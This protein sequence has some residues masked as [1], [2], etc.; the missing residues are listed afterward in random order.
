MKYEDI[1]VDYF[2]DS[3]STKRSLT[4]PAVGDTKEK[5]TDFNSQL[6]NPY[7]DSYV[8]IRGEQLDMKGMLDALVG[9]EN[10]MRS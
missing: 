5:V 4:H 10:V 3:D 7:K 9:R 1:A 8:W 6:K 2:A